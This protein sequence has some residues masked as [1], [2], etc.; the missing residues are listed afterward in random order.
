MNAPEPIAPDPNIGKGKPRPRLFRALGKSEPPR[1]IEIDGRL[2]DFEQCFKHDSWAATATYRAREDRP[3]GLDHIV[4]KF[5]RTQSILGLPMGWLGRRLARREDRLLRRLSDLPNIPRACG[6]IRADGKPLHTAVGHEFVPGHPM[7]TSER[8]D[9]DFF[10]ELERLIAEMHRRGIAYVDL[11]KPENIIVG[12]DGRPYLIDF[13][14]CWS[15]APGWRGRLWP[16]RAWLRTL[17]R[18]DLYHLTKHVMRHTDD[19]ENVDEDAIDRMRP[20]PNRV[21]RMVGKPAR[22]VRRRVLVLLG[23]RRGALGQ[24]LSEAAP[25]DAVRREIQS[26]ST[27][28]AQPPG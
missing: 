9:R 6:Q 25:E 24:S 5:N 28:P 21:A 7:G 15:S 1:V 17:Q 2:Y 19:P 23:V 16:A 20:W 18:S 14:I 22:F 3:G 13:Q 4:C 10:T 11:H 26:R 27:T 12:D 8:I